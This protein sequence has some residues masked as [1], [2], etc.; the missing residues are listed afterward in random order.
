ML[1]KKKSHPEMLSR[2]DYTCFVKLKKSMRYLEKQKIVNPNFLEEKDLFL[3][4][5]NKMVEAGLD[6]VKY[7]RLI[8]KDDLEREMLDWDND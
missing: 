6:D 4:E 2:R 5:Y 8:S 7:N 1:V 3:T